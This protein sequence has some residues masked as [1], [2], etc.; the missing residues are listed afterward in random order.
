M[1]PN[2]HLKRKI[3]VCSKMR[4]TGL[5]D[6]LCRPLGLGYEDYP[7][8]LQQ[9]AYPV[10]HD[11]RTPDLG[12]SLAG[13][14]QA[15]VSGA[16]NL[17]FIDS[18]CCLIQGITCPRNGTVLREFLQTHGIVAPNILAIDV[19][20]IA[21]VLGALN[22]QLPD[23]QFSVADAA[24]LSSFA[25]GSV[26]VLVQDHLLN[27]AP[28]T[29]HE[30][31]IREAARLLDPRGFLIL[32]FSVNPSAAENLIWT[33]RE[34]ETLIGA[35][36]DDQ[37]YCLGD[38]GLEKSN[39]GRVIIEQIGAMVRLNK[40][41]SIIVTP[42]T[43]NFEFYFPKSELEECLERYHLR[44]IFVTNESGIDRN[45]FTCIRYRTIVRHCK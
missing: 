45:G 7:Y 27:C 36:L 40:N 39:P 12:A 13:L 19:A 37:A 5:S 9:Y 28:H 23:V 1:C 42:P 34:F 35:S 24:H 26:Q 41:R 31:I 15:G 4:V 29:T 16:V 11:G 14:Q 25:N 8:L 18:P 17:G 38:L 10:V 22:M 33:R 43:G 3:R 6:A 44:F 21:A 30:G 20:D 32:N 2:L